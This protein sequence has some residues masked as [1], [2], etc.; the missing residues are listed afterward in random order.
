MTQITVQLFG[1]PRLERDGALLDIDRRKALALFAYLATSPISHSRDALATLLW[2]EYDHSRARAALRRTLSTLNSALGS[3]WSVAD[4]DSVTVNPGSGLQLDVERF[5]VLLRLPHHH[6]GPVLCPD[7]LRSLSDAVAFYRADFMAGFGLPDSPEFD[8]WQFF[9][10]EELRR[11]QA[12]ALERLARHHSSR[13]DSDAALVYAGRLVAL[14]ALHE[15][16]HRLLMELYARSGRD[17]AALRQYAECA[18]LLREELGVA[19]E[20]E[21]NR[22]REAI[23]RGRALSADSTPPVTP[24]RTRALTGRGREVEQLVD[25]LSRPDCKMLVLV[26]LGGRGKPSLELETI[27]SLAAL[28]PHQTYVA[29]VGEGRAWKH[30]GHDSGLLERAAS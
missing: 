24:V 2:P 8:E 21:T 14:D 28:F 9:Q 27:E 20:G 15:P 13:F 10:S 16:A 11:G 5:R 22:L 18:R 30:F 3:G 7:C 4:R 25:L 23:E 17:S 19:P 6:P 1:Y 29:R 12:S 26:D